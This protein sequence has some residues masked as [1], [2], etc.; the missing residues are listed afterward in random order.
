MQINHFTNNTHFTPP[1]KGGALGATRLTSPANTQRVGNEMDQ[2]QQT[3]L[4]LVCKLLCEIPAR[5]SQEGSFLRNILSSPL[6]TQI[7]NALATTII[8]GK[9]FEYEE[10]TLISLLEPFPPL[11]RKGLIAS[12]LR[13]RRYVALG[14]GVLNKNEPYRDPALIAVKAHFT[15]KSKP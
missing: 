1:L 13:A 8:S 4:K 2:A 3:A 14:L 7:F 6:E 10:S 5:Q 15:K 12:L 11:L 9:L